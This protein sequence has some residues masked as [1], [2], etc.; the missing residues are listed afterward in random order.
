MQLDW[1]QMDRETLIER[2]IEPEYTDIWGRTHTVS[3]ETAQAILSSLGEPPPRGA[4]D[5]AIVIRENADAISIRI[6][7][8]QSGASIKL[9]I[10]WEGGE[11]QHR[12]FWAPELRTLES[13]DGVI[14][15]RLPL[16]TLRLGYHRLR[17]YWMREPALERFADSAFI[18]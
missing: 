8:A 10:E 18:V 9:E 16:T 11:L 15:K 13:V 4:I 12:W 7:E 6:P 14:V 5:P 3:D 1:S 2:G 17:L